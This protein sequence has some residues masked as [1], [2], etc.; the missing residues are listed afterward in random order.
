MILRL[1]CR[2]W[3]S[4]SVAFGFL[5]FEFREFKL[6]RWGLGSVARL[7]ARGLGFEVQGSGFLL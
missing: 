5:K 6:G 3:G 1:D 7:R 4:G 2:V